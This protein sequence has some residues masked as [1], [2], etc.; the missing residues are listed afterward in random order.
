MRAG[1]SLLLIGC[2]VLGGIA[3]AGC[4]GDDDVGELQRRIDELEAENA[5]L[6]GLED[7]EASD[8]LD[9]LDQADLELL[10]SLPQEHVGEEPPERELPGVDIWAS[11]P[12]AAEV[13]PPPPPEPTTP[14]SHPIVLPAPP[15]RE[16]EVAPVEENPDPP[17]EPGIGGP[18][19]ELQELEGD[20]PSVAETVTEPPAPAVGGPRLAVHRAV[21]G[22]DVVGREPAGV[23]TRF[24][25]TVVK[26]YC[27][28]EVS[29]IGTSGPTT[30]EHRWTLA[31]E[32]Q[33]VTE[34]RI[35]GDRWRTFSNRTVSEKPGLWQVELVDDRGIV[36]DTLSFT[37][38]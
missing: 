35:G 16:D 21:L 27:F 24:P 36:L 23:A 3:T 7:G 9:G 22:T 8:S 17:L 14:E 6:R 4:G 25:R 33:G 11:P 38:E 34:L 5:K 26:V 30:L 28:S 18:G 20:P 2:A 19:A 1:Y 10:E 29:V 15:Q 13:T 37:V 12:P 31:G 32:D